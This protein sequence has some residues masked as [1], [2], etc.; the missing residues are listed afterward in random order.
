MTTARPETRAG[1][2]SLEA[3]GLGV[4]FPLRSG[5]VAVALDGAD[6]TVR[7]GEVLALVGESGSGKTTLART[8]TGLERPTHGEVVV[9]GLPLEHGTRALKAF[10]RRVPMLLQDP[11]GAL[12]PRHTVYASL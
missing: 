8:L 12:N 2:L 5:H 7:S 10:R 4:E 3:R 1:R 6:L 11:D 9:D